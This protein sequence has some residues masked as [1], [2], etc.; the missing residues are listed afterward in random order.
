MSCEGIKADWVLQIRTFSCEKV[1][2]L[3][4][5][6]LDPSMLLGFLV[7][8]EAEWRDLRARVTEVRFS[9]FPLLIYMH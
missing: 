3:P 8:D 6:G 9:A 4:L 7:R 5:A 1:R 2:K